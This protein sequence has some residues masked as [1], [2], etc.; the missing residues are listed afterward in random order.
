MHFEWCVRAF[1]WMKR[2]SDRTWKGCATG[3]RSGSGVVSGMVL[4]MYETTS[5]P[6]F[7]T[8]GAA[9]A[10]FLS[11]MCSET[12]MTEHTPRKRHDT[13]RQL[14]LLAT[15]ETLEQHC[16]RKIASAHSATCHR[17][18][19]VDLIYSKTKV[20]RKENLSLSNCNFGDVTAPHSWRLGNAPLQWIPKGSVRQSR[21]FHGLAI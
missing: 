16:L 3:L 8:S 4:S 18:A 11:V 12:M 10:W 1:M 21:Y 9:T 5:G 15:Y 2:T 17:S 7:Y 6:S 19:T 14:L 20:R 13:P